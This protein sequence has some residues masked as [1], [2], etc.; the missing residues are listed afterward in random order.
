MNLGVLPILSQ[1]T[2]RPVKW[3]RQFEELIMC[4]S[5][6]FLRKRCIPIVEL[7]AGEM[8]IQIF[9]KSAHIKH[10][11]WKSWKEHKFMLF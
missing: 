1:M 10:G 4:L 5:F 8:E 6:E 2:G 11:N 9:P 3:L 7:S